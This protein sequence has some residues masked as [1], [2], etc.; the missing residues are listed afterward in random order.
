MQL[1][2]ILVYLLD[3]SDHNLEPAPEL[4]QPE[5]GK[6]EERA[7]DTPDHSEDNAGDEG[8]QVHVYTILYHEQDIFLCWKLAKTLI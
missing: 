3:V 1:K 2:F 6:D 8:Q 7:H 5:V 4:G